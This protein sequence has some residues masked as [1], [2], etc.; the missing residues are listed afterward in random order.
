MV[1]SVSNFIPS[2]PPVIARLNSRSS[3][4]SPRAWPSTLTT[5]SQQVIAALQRRSLTFFNLSA[6][7]TVYI[8]PAQDQNG[9]P[10]AAAVN[11]P[12]CI[13]IPAGAGMTLYEAAS[14]FNACAS[15]GGT[16]FTIW[17]FLEGEVAAAL[18]FAIGG[19]SAP[20]VS[21]LSIDGGV[22]L[23]AAAALYPSAPV[24]SAGSLWS[25]G[26]IVTVVPGITPNPSAPPVF[27][28]GL[29]AA[30]L[31]ALGGGNLPLTNPGAGSGQLW[32]NGGIVCVA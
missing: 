15:V 10:L 22:L 28:S 20:V 23:V 11:G 9:N 31:L 17:E 3:S 6:T 29:T 13:A 21:N 7:A 14:A 19:G 2:G 8:C 32:N 1:A 27:Y 16:P 30:A 5:G 4:L 12:G 26:G 24:M 25:N 18:T